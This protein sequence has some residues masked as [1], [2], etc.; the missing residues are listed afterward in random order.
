M[1]IQNVMGNGVK[2]ISSG[3]ET[4]SEVSTILFHS[5]LLNIEERGTRTFFLYN[6]FKKDVFKN[7]IGLV[8]TTQS[9]M[10]FSS[11]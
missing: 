9:R 8:T 7:C 6:W 2:V 11:N 5:R 1:L 4:A 10:Y 3:E